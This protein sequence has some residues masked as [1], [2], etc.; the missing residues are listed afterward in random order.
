M[1]DNNPEYS[2]TRGLNPQSLRLADVAR[3]LS[4]SGPKSVS[5]E[6]LQA[7]LHAG[8]PANTDGSMNLIHYCAWL[9]KETKHGGD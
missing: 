4:L 8:A 6:M 2:E 3:I 9:A 1:S 7:D 5:V